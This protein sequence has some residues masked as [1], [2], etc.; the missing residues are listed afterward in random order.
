MLKNSLKILLT[1]S[2]V[3]IIG[4]M[5]VEASDLDEESMSRH[6][7]S[8]IGDIQP[9]DVCKKL[10]SKIDRRVGLQFAFSLLNGPVTAHKSIDTLVAEYEAAGENKEAILAAVTTLAVYGN[11]TTFQGLADLNAKSEAALWISSRLGYFAHKILPIGHSLCDSVSVPGF[12]EKGLYLTGEFGIFTTAM[13]ALE[14][15]ETLVA[16]GIGDSVFNVSV[17]FVQGALKFSQ[18]FSDLN[19]SARQDKKPMPNLMVIFEKAVNHAFREEQNKHQRD[20]QEAVSFSRGNSN[21]GFSAADGGLTRTNLGRIDEGGSVQSS[22]DRMN[23]GLL[24]GKKKQ[25]LYGT[26]TKP[27]PFPRTDIVEEEK[28]SCCESCIIM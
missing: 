14:S 10:R 24:D 17:Y 11:G 1:G 9:K 8:T 28:T 3:I 26:D 5:N 20:L 18:T 21:T 13:K 23:V 27:L 6:S 22:P 12:E 2:L 7:S 15:R 16:D 19:A 25:Q 4:S